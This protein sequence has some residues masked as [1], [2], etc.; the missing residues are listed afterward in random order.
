MTGFY[1]TPIG[2][3]IIEDIDESDYDFQNLTF[4]RG[5]NEKR[6]E[7]FK[8]KIARLLFEIDKKDCKIIAALFALQKGPMEFVKMSDLIMKLVE[9]GMDPVQKLHEKEIRPD[10][11]AKLVG[12]KLKSGSRLKEVLR[13]YNDFNLIIYRRNEIL[14]NTEKINTL[15]QLNLK[16]FKDISNS[17]F[18]TAL[19]KVYDLLLENKTDKLKDPYLPIIP[20]LQR[21]VCYELKTTPDTFKEI[22]KGFPTLFNNRQIVLSP[23]RKPVK[24]DEFIERLGRKRYFLRKGNVVDEERVYRTILRDWQEGR[25]RIK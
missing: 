21:M 3:L 12:Y 25:I 18:F 7:D 16:S 15:P 2:K 9:L 22:I 1:L 10:K 17:E 20:K 8:N 13:Y 24:K 11:F 14:L 23:A 5:R 4:K 19:N 6:Y